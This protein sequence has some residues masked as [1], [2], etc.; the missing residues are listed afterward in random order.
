ME[1]NSSDS[2]L[3]AKGRPTPPHSTT[4]KQSNKPV[5]QIPV[6]K[7]ETDWTDIIVKVATPLFTVIGLVIG[8]WKYQDE[9]AHNDGLEFRRKMWEKRLESYTQL[10]D[11]AAKLVTNVKNK[12]EFDTLSVRFDQ[13]YWGKLPLFDDDSVE[14]H[15]KQ[16]SDEVQSFRIGQGDTAVLKVDGYQLVKSCQ[17]SL[18]TS[19][20]ELYEK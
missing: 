11:V 12:P 8:V 6:Q 13:L 9:Q 16:F 5:N 19:W 14:L 17:K 15:L 4:S 10:G 1:P 18:H 7:K 20:N 3:P 2:P